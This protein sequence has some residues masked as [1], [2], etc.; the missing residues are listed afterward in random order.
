MS[1]VEIKQT[2][3]TFD[4]RPI[5]YSISENGYLIYLGGQPWV[6]Q[7]TDSHIPYPEL[8]LEGSCLKQIE[9]ITAPVEHRA[10]LEEKVTELLIKTL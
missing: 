7:S 1:N 10:T 4:G 6:S 2:D 3:K 5:S 8:G 9:D